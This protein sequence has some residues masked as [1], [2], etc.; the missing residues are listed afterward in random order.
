MYSSEPRWIDR[1]TLVRKGSV[2]Q[3]L[4]EDFEKKNRTVVNVG[5][6]EE[7]S[8]SKFEFEVKKRSKKFQQIKKRAR[9]DSFEF[10]EVDEGEATG[11]RKLSNIIPTSSTKSK[12]SKTHQND[13]QKLT[14]PPVLPPNKPFICTASKN[15]IFGLKNGAQKILG[16]L[17]NTKK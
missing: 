12:V 5:K 16:E 8:E 4:L 7:D 2:V 13:T 10:D 9:G 17:R 1:Y 14:K 15:D 11:G 3:R 6:I